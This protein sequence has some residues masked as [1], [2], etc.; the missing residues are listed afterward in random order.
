MDA[1]KMDAMEYAEVL[2]QESFAEEVNALEDSF[3]DV[4][5]CHRSGVCPFD[6]E[7]DCDDMEGGM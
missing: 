7:I 4:D 3:C 5:I 1:V 2:A 6:G